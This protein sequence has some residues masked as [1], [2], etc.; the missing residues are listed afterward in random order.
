VHPI[1]AVYGYSLLVYSYSF[2]FLQS[3]LKRN[4]GMFCLMV[5][6]KLYSKSL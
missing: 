2:S 6:G 5:A 4:G 3:L 1:S